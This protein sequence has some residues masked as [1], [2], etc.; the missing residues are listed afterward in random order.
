MGKPVIGTRMGG[1][2]ELI[3][4]ERTGL[5]YEA[6]DE[7]TLANQINRLLKYPKLGVELGKNARKKAESVFSPDY[8]YYQMLNKYEKLLQ[9]NN[10]TCGK[11]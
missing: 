8:H 6:G 1:I 11:L 10:S 7:K 9:K 2:P 5:V 3:D 4:H